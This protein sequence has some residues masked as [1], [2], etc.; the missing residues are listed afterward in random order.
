M[1]PL[2][3]AAFGVKFGWWTNQRD[4][5]KVKIFFKPLLEFPI[6]SITTR[7]RLALKYYYIFSITLT[8]LMRRE[9]FVT[10]ITMQGFATVI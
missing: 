9:K 3:N 8:E 5:K 4:E 10:S 1:A 6:F 2:K 7:V